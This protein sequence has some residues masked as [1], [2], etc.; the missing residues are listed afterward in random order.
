[1]LYHAIHHTIP[2]YTMYYTE[3]LKSDGGGRHAAEQEGEN[4]LPAAKQDH[5]DK[6]D[7][8][9]GD[10]HGDDD[11]DGGDVGGGDHG[12]DDAHHDNH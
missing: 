12:D 6:V 5:R 11:D 10:H 1:M 8:G 9:G 3:L 2:Y 7:V 4:R